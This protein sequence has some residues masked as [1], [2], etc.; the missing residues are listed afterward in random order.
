MSFPCTEIRSPLLSK[1]LTAKTVLES[2]RAILKSVILS[3]GRFWFFKKRLPIRR[4][5]SATNKEFTII[6]NN[7]RLRISIFK[8]LFK[9]NFSPTKKS[10]NAIPKSESKYSS[11]G[12][13]S[14]NSL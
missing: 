3:M 8:R 13:Y 14:P 4:R 6:L 5:P 10:N 12:G 1:T 11:L 7:E 9:S 2:D